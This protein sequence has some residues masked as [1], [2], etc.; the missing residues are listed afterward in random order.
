MRR[1]HPSNVQFKDVSRVETV[2]HSSGKTTSLQ[3]TFT[4]SWIRF[5]RED[6]FT[7]DTQNLATITGYCVQIRCGNYNPEEVKDLMDIRA[8]SVIKNVGM[9]SRQ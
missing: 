3:G 4:L 6:R 9:F 8:Y 5:I 7:K 1:T 2:K